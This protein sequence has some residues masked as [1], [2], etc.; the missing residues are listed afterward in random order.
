MKIGKLR[1]R[2][3]IIGKTWQQDPM[4]GEMLEQEAPIATVWAHFSPLSAR[5]FI[6][7]RAIQSETIAL[8]VIRYPPMAV[9]ET[10][11]SLHAI[12]DLTHDQHYGITG[13]LADN[14]S[15]R[16]YLTLMLKKL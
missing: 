1:H 10:I 9:S 15:G 6:A 4:T 2:I 12:H 8:C 16:E 7:A 13:V 5:E 14:K 3:T 11:N